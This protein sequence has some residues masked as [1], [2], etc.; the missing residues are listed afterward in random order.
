[1]RKVLMLLLFSLLIVTG[2]SAQKGTVYTI[3]VDTLQGSETVTLTP[4]NINGTYSSLSIS[5]LCTELGGTSD[6]TAT[7]MVSNDG[8]NYTVLNG[9]NGSLWVAPQNLVNDSTQNTMTVF[10]AATLNWT[11][12]D[13]A[14]RWYKVVTTGTASDTTKLQG[15]YVYK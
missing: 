1:M 7:L 6:G 3:P 5:V 8:T 12:P 9:T 13:P 15:T 2:I 11:L 4:F 14:W 10:A